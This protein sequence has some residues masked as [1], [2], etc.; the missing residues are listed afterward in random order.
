LYQ[1]QLGQT[2]WGSFTVSHRGQT[3]RAEAVSFQ[4]LA[5]PARVLAFDFFFL[6]TAIAGQPSSALS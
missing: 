3:L 6:G 5:R 2:T 1:P 4:L